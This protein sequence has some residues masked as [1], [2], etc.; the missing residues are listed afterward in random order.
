MNTD[1]HHP[2]ISIVLPTLGRVERLRIALESLWRSTEIPVE[3]IVVSDEKASLKV[4]Q[5]LNCRA[6]QRTAGPIEAWNIGAAEAMGEWIA[7]GADDLIYHRNWAEEAL[8]A[9]IGGYVGFNDMWSKGIDW[10][11]HFM[12]TR[13]FMVQHNGGCLAIPAYRSWYIDVETGYRAK[14]AGVYVLAKR[15]IVE[16]RHWMLGGAQNDKTYRNGQKWHEIDKE[17]FERRKAEGF[18]DDF[19]PVIVEKLEVRS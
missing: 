12:M 10:A 14:R 19:D 15:A 4:A 11:T 8:K 17:V 18:I 3:C 6:I 1:N 5:T 7:L 13:E 16:H 9:N 2:I